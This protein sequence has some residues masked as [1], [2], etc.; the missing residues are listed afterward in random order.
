M[1]WAVKKRVLYFS[2]FL[3]VIIFIIGGSFFL[4]INTTPSCTDEVKNQNEVGIDCGGPCKFFCDSQMVDLNILWTRS[5]L[6]APGVYNSVAYM[7]NSNMKAGI[8][9]I[10]YIFKLFDK[11]GVLI[12]ERV[13]KD[14]VPPGKTFAI[15]EPAV[16]V[17]NR[18]VART[19]IKIKGDLKW[20]KM[21]K[22]KRVFEIQDVVKEL[23]QK[24]P[25]IT[26]TLVNNLTKEISNIEI[27][28]TIFD[29]EGNALNASQT[30]VEK[31][32]KREKKEIFFTWQ[33]PIKEEVSRIDI[34]PIFNS[35]E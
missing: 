9:E 4:F 3:A 12:K 5:F 20:K 14:F 28:A 6:I 18:I 29:L 22:F 32:G 10:K 27:T 26:A 13:G 7:E 23:N 24:N 25:K 16:R 19:D 35:T 34:K 17:G 8:K 30:Y 33:K 2:V 11:K 31:I 1:S 21:K 15:F